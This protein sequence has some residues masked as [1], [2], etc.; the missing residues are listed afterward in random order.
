MEGEKAVFEKALAAG[1]VEPADTQLRLV[2]E[3]VAD[4]AAG[5]AATLGARNPNL[6]ICRVVCPDV[7][8]WEML[9]VAGLPLV[10]FV[11]AMGAR[12]ITRLLLG[13]FEVVPAEDSLICA[14]ASRDDELIREIWVHTPDE[15]RTRQVGVWLKNAAALQ[16][17][18]PFRWLLGLASDANLD[19]AVELMVENR[20]VGA[21]CEVEATGFDLKRTR[22][23]RALSCWDRTTSLVIMP[24]PSLPSVPASTLL[25]WHV[26]ALRGWDIPCD[27][28][29]ALA[30]EQVVWAA[31]APRIDFSLLTKEPAKRVLLVGQTLNGV[32]FGFF[33]NNPLVG[34]IRRRDPALK[35]TI[36]VLEHPTEEQRKWQLQDPNYDVLVNE[37]WLRFGAGFCVDAVGCLHIGRAPEFGMTELDASFICLKPTG[38]SEWSHTEVICWEL[39]S[40]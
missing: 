39:W 16:L 28:P 20:L 35:S 5:F 15:V 18:L 22:P 1:K 31:T 11:F 29:E 23:A 33:A 40:V 21:L 4:N 19:V 26:R 7:L 37:R 13:F 24:T 14:L 8:V 38:Q 34:A 9:D 10:D 36:F 32:V 2:A 25:A 6:S 17:D 30:N 27:A 12:E 3:V